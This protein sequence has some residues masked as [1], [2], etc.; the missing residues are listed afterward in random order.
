QTH[1][2]IALP[3]PDGSFT[4][5]VFLPNTGGANSFAELGTPDAVQQLFQRDFADAIEL[6]PDYAAQFFANPTG[7][8]GTL[9]APNWHHRDEVLLIG[10]A[11][12]AIVP[13]HGQGMNCAFEDCVELLD[14]LCAD[15]KVRADA[16]ATFEAQRR[17]NARA[18]AE[19][20]VE[21]YR[22]MRDDVASPRFR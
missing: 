9:H 22:E 11:A 6:V 4:A 13:F 15:G 5:T 10:D 1:M 2:M 3:N 8:L 18:I 20:A 19:M 21:N 17:P 7:W 16:F 14:L 12:H